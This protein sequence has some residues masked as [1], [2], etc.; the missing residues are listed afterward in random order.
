MQLLCSRNLKPQVIVTIRADHPVEYVVLAG[1]SME[2]T[3]PSLHTTG[4]SLSYKNPQG[5][6]CQLT[7]DLS[8]LLL[9][10]LWPYFAFVLWVFF[11]NCIIKAKCCWE[12]GGAT[13]SAAGFSLL[14]SLSWSLS[15]L[16]AQCCKCG[17]RISTCANT[18]R[19][20]DLC[21][22]SARKWINVDTVEHLR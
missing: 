8:F 11:F 6:R 13:S 1:D 20:R 3:F 7:A 18:A 5:K 12:G 16:T 17:S 9:C 14:H 22:C 15:R 10:N 2:V 19:G 4:L 21:S